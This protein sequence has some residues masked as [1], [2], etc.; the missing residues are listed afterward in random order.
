M[1]SESSNVSIS[2]EVENIP[3]SDEL[4][5]A[6]PNNYYDMAINGG[7]DFELLFTFSDL[8]KDIL[9]QI[10]VI[11]EIKEIGLNQITYN[12]SGDKYSPNLNQW[13]HFE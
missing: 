11:G 2:I 7:E 8:P 12:L 6:F 9:D 13:R 4:K 1:P 5:N 3:I 10:T